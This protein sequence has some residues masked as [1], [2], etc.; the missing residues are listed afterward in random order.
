MQLVIVNVL[1]LTDDAFFPCLTADV[2]ELTAPPRVVPNWR[3]RG[4]VQSQRSKKARANLLS[5]LWRLEPESKG[6]E[7]SLT[8]LTLPL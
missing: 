5:K 6:H 1:T 8:G 3:G 2:T 4:W 7:S